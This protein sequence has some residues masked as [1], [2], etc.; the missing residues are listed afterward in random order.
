METLAMKQWAVQA[1]YQDKV[2]HPFAAMK[3]ANVNSRKVKSLHAYWIL[4][5]YS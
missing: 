1:F 3:E 4:R 5:K 2:L